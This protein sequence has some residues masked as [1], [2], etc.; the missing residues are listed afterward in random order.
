MKAIINRYNKATLIAA[1]L[2]ITGATAIFGTYAAGDDE[3]NRPDGPNP[4]ACF[5]MVNNLTDEQKT[6]MQQAQDLM[7][8]GDKEGAKAILDELGFKPPMR[9]DR[10]EMMENLTDEQKAR[11]EE[12]HKLMQAGDKEGAK[13][14]FDELGIKP[15]MP[16]HWKGF[17]PEWNNGQEKQE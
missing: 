5:E 13:A 10:K 15:P 11:L 9:H 4:L 16:R 14:I 3:E 17:G 12:A 7:T 8:A 1:A 6:K 2:I